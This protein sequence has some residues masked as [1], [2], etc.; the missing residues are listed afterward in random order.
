MAIFK[1][2]DFLKI[3]KRGNLRAVGGRVKTLLN[4]TILDDS[5]CSSLL[6][7]RLLALGWAVMKISV[8][9]LRREEFGMGWI[10]GEM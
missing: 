1:F 7:Q 10:S 9:Y 6:I 5:I 2:I 8:Q 4:L 3:H